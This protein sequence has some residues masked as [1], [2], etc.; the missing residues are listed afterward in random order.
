M[1]D[2]LAQLVGR[3]LSSVEFVQDYLQLRFD[4]PTLTVL[5]PIRV[6]GGAD[7]ARS[8]EDQF[9]NALCG[10]IAKVVR[11]VLLIRDGDLT[12]EFADGSHIAVSLRP[13][14]YVGPEAV[15]CDGFEAGTWMVI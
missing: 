11:E 14:D 7:V 2:L 12:L 9:R 1:A 15:I 6:Y 10:Q 13:E 3:K 5:N 8:G 4:G